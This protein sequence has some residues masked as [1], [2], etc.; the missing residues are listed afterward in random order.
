L[1]RAATFLRKIGVEMGFE[2]EGH[3]RTRIVR[4]TTAPAFSAQTEGG[5][6]PSAPSAP[7][8]KSGSA[9]GLVAPGLRTVA[10]TVAKNGAGRADGRAQPIPPPDRPTARTNALKYNEEHDA[11]DADAKIP[12]PVAPEKT[13]ASGPGRNSWAAKDWLRYFDEH[14]WIAE[15]DHGLPPPAAEARALE[16]CVVEWLNQNFERSPP[17]HCLA[18]RGADSA[19]DPLLPYGSEPTGHAWLHSR[20]WPA[21]HARRKAEAVAALKAMG[22]TQSAGFPDD[23]GKNGNA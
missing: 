21:W 18:C 12:S 20:C 3:A 8:Q 15:F 7:T 11:D 23:F 4:I 5:G 10:R 19:H 13:G 14:A 22:I 6:R 2:R 9:N 1:R 16:C 17:G